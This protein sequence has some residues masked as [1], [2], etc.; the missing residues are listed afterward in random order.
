MLWG[1][2]AGSTTAGT[3][4]AA[5]VRTLG[6]PGSVIVAGICSSVAS[7]ALAS[8]ALEPGAVPFI[9]FVEVIDAPD[10][11]GRHN[12]KLAIIYARF[13]MPR[14]LQTAFTFR[15]WGGSRPGAGRPPNP[16]RR[17]VPHRERRPHDRHCP[18]HVTL[19]AAAGVPALRGAQVFGA[20]R[21]ALAASSAAG[22]RILHFSAQQDH[23]HLL[24]E[25]DAPARFV[26]GVQGLMIRVAKAVNRACGRHGRVWGD[27][28]HARW[29][30]SPRE[31]RAALVYVLRNVAK[32]L[33][34][35][36]GMDLCSSSAWFDGWRVP[37]ARPPGP[38]PI[39]P[40]RTW[41]ARV[42]WIQHGRL[43]VE[44]VPRAARGG[45]GVPAD[46]PRGFRQNSR[47]AGRHTLGLSHP[48]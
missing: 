12:S 42:G 10:S 32:H 30:A 44:E 22:F 45:Y 27:R 3:I 14:P 16:G 46:I 25:A 21:G 6:M 4:A 23:V 11:M 34:S 26:R 24:V 40:P 28:Y 2:Q 1:G 8:A 39:R 7:D 15:S 5:F 41:L 35:I 19:R 36:R 48:R 9:G 38:V 29:L 47:R 43:D 37:P 17:C 18:V 13:K 33:P 20:V 31:V